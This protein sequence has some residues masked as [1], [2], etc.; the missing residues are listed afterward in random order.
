MPAGKTYFLKVTATGCTNSPVE[1]SDMQI[2]NMITTTLRQS[3]LEAFQR[4]NL[5]ARLR[6]ILNAA[7]FAKTERLADFNEHISDLNPTRHVRGVQDI[8]VDRITGSLGRAQDF[9]RKFRPLK[10]HLRDRWVR[11]YLDLE[12]DRWEPIR[13]H[14]IGAEYFV[15]DGHHRVSV[16]RHTG[17]A[18]IQ[19]EVWEY[20]ADQKSVKADLCAPLKIKRQEAPVATCNSA[21]YQACQ[22]C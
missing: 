5:R 14:K 2:N 13:V 15:E 3:A 20:T 18:F 7:M 6:Q 10:K 19:A 1:R 8:H 11:N 16:A 21:A 22:A 12:S 4:S 17:L 9:D